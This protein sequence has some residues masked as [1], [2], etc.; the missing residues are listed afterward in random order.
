MPTDSVP[1]VGS[2]TPTQ[3]TPP[4]REPKQTMDGEMFMHLLVTQLQN[5]DPSS[6]MD[7]NQMISQTTQLA[8]MESI[9]AM[10]TTSE[11]NF[12]LQ[13]RSVAA[14]FV[15]QEV[16]YFD[17]DGSLL[18]GTATSVSYAGPVPQVVVDGL[19]IPLDLIAGINAAGASGESGPGEGNNDAGAS[20]SDSGTS[21]AGTGSDTSGADAAATSGGTAA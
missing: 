15:G 11:E 14:A 5:Q 7:T 3:T 6:P 20:P 17:S 4:V 13:M 12:S 2:V 19:A 21:T 9:S 16:T 18:S 1:P 8:M 10:T